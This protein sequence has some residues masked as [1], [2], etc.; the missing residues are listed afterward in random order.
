MIRRT[1]F[2]AFMLVLVAALAWPALAQRG[3][4]GGRLAGATR[5]ETAVAVSQRAF[6]DGAAAAYLARADD[7]ADAV[8]AGSLDD[9]PV[10]LVPSCGELPQVVAAELVRLAPAEVFAVGGPRA[11][12]DELLD[13]AVAAA[14]AGDHPGDAAAH[15]VEAEVDLVDAS[16]TPPFTVDATDP[17]VVTEGTTVAHEI[18]FTGTFGAAWLDD[19]RFSGVLRDGDGQLV[20][21]GRGCAP[22]RLEDQTGIACTDDLVALEVPQGATTASTVRLHTDDS[23]VGAT[24]LEPGTYVLDQPVRWGTDGD[25]A[26][27]DGAVTVR[28]T[29]TVHPPSEQARLAV[30]EWETPDGSYLTDGH[31]PADLA[32]IEAAIAAGEG[33]GIP[34]GVLRWGDGGVNIG[35]RWHVTDVELV[36]VTMEL[37]DG[38]AQ[39]VDD[40]TERWITEVGRF[41]PWSATPVAVTH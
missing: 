24:P 9:G 27:D 13:A 31:P 17:G 28:V 34:N 32:R 3:T 23:E 1:L 36:D 4:T 18:R 12:C 20:V 30:V 10:L 6:P 41:C 29:Y 33:V 5:I 11:V 21:A 19:P 35:H 15:V 22:H 38:T 2:A 26:F 37:C 8:S 39:M 14:Q 7:P 25:F 16:S 40:E